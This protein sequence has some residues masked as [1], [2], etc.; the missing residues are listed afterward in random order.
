MKP[1]PVVP[2]SADL[3]HQ[4]SS[5]RFSLKALSL[6]GAAL[7]V[8]ALR[9]LPAGSEA[10]VVK[11]IIDGDTV[12]LADGRRLRYIGIDTPELHRKVGDRWVKKPEPFGQEAFDRNRQWVLGRRVRLEFDV[13]SRDR[14]GRLLAYVYVGDI[15]VNAELVKEGFAQPLTIPPNVRHA[16]LFR[17]LAAEAR[18][19]RRGL[20]AVYAAD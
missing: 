20:W 6:G 8:F 13:Q 16:E 3:K 7:V 4:R 2:S 15:M 11:Q 18:S 17:G 1:R 19:N 14:Y 10:V 9:G 5:L 12:E